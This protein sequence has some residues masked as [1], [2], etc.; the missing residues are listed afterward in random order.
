MHHKEVGAGRGSSHFQEKG[1]LISQK[2]LESQERN[3]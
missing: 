3:N 1:D 2:E